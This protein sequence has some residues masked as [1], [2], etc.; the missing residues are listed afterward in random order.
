LS[1]GLLAVGAAYLVLQGAYSL[2]LKN[3]VILDVFAI[4]LGFVLRVVAGAVVIGVVVS[5]WLL[6]CTILLALFLGLCKRRH[7]LLML[8]GGAPNHRSVLGHYSTYLLDQMISVIAAASVIAYALYTMAEQTVE[9]FGTA[10]LIFTVPFVL[11]GILRYLY[12]VHQRASG[13]D[14]EETLLSDKP[15]MA[16]VLLWVAAVALIVYLKPGI[17]P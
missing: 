6:I 1:A 2:W 11:Y 7:E 8:E 4:A 13:G 10:N 12:L 3:V 17:G 5:P 16:D 9:R 14:P 15:L